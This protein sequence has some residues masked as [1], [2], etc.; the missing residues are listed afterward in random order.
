MTTMI[1]MLIRSENQRS[2][3]LPTAFDA[4]PFTKILKTIRVQKLIELS[5]AGV[6]QKLNSDPDKQ[7]YTGVQN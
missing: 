6:D 1:Y 3:L 7:N 4:M 5:S 2:Y